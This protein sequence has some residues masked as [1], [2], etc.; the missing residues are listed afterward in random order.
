MFVSSDTLASA[1]GFLAY[2]FRIST[3]FVED[4]LFGHAAVLLDLGN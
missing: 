4:L 1:A 2:G 3:T